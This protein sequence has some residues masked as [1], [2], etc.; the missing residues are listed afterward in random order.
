MNV[1]MYIIRGGGG[2]L[3]AAEIFEAAAQVVTT[4]L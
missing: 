2:L 1:C 3:P 4:G